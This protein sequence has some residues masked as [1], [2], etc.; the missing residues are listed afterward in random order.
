M[1][2]AFPPCFVL[3]CAAVS[4]EA[5][6]KSCCRC[7]ERRGVAVLFELAAGG[8]QEQE[9]VTNFTID[10]DGDN[11]G[12]RCLLSASTNASRQN[13]APLP[14]EL[15]TVWLVSRPSALNSAAKST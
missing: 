3:L 13:C 14:R 2:P 5:P 15:H 1:L 7:N 11:R 6:P 10:D 8:H 4:K 12:E 9:T